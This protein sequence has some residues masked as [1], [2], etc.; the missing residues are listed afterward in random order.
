ML[1]LG[2]DIGTSSLKLGAIDANR[3]E[4]VGWA[5]QNYS[6]EHPQPGWSEL[7]A[8][9]YWQAMAGSLKELGKTVN[10]KDIRALSISAQGQTFVPINAEGKTLQN[11]WT[12]I[13]NR[14]VPQA[15]ALKRTFDADKAFRKTGV[16][17]GAGSFAAM[18]KYVRENKPEI[19]DKTSK[20]LI[21]NSYLIWRL[22]GRA[23]I[24]E[25]QAA[26]VGMY[27]WH[28]HQWW[29]EMLDAIGVKE[30]QLPE[31]LPSGTAVGKILPEVADELG[32]SR[33]LLV[34]TGANDQT[35]NAIGA[36]LANEKNALVILGTA[37]VIFNVLTGDVQPTRAGIWSPYPIREKSYQLGFT[38]SGCGTLD[39]AKKMLVPELDFPAVFELAAK[40]PAG[41]HGVRCLIDLDG[42]A[43]ND[44]EYRGVFAGLSRKTDRADMLRAVLEGIAFSVRELCDEMGWDLRGKIV[45]TAG[46]GARSDFWMQML[47]DVLGCEIQRLG[48]EQSGVAGGAI[49]AAVAAGAFASYPA[50]IDRCVRTAGSFS[51]RAAESATYE[52]IYQGFKKLRLAGDE[53]YG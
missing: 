35:A 14:A 32:L 29:R 8:D 7:C 11:A 23:V 6:L 33:E 53:Y 22:T 16:G 38:N 5:G 37:L 41:C 2:V 39:W 48:H 52:G 51:P 30:T 43:G 9:C 27:D 45:R 28:A 17:I 42:R 20:F 13:D 26:M 47:A 1:F 25:N 18:L 49:M 44:G 15:E 46:G 31:P 50:A 36:G 34:V 24:D 19:F 3:G 21:T 10:L 12:W 40:S 4:F